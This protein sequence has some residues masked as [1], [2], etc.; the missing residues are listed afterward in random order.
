MRG[1]R[2]RA[3]FLLAAVAGALL[4]GG[5]AL[6]HPLSPSLLRFEAA[7]GGEVT[8]LWRTPAT[9]PTGA[10]TAPALPEGCALHEVSPVERRDEAVEQ[11]MRLDCGDEGLVGR[12]LGVT[13][14]LDGGPPVILHVDLPGGGTYRE[15]LRADRPTV[16][17]PA[18]QGARDVFG[19]YLALG[20]EHLVF[21]AD[22][23]LFVLGLLLLLRGRR[24][25]IAVTSFTVGHSVTLALAA[26]ELVRVSEQ[27][28]EIAI[29]A[30]L[31][32]LADG[33]V[34]RMAAPGGAPEPLIAR[35]PW[36]VPGAFGLL[37]GMGFAGA[38]AEIGLPSE[39]IAW[40]LLAFNLGL[41]VGQLA[42]IGLVLGA[43]AAIPRAARG[44]LTW[45]PW[46]TACLIGA[47]GV[48]WMVERALW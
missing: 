14:L 30:S 25:I 36:V 40:S 28:V 42:V 6:A 39:G 24:L 34:R 13:G 31:L 16:F 12:R 5:P 15:L 20:I 19:A 48:G 35:R 26:L 23:V 46:A 3:A 38:L 37:H 10:T 11:R 44:A 33:A 8:V 7:A 17:V 27:L 1:A 2:R 45:L 43:A 32:V 21:G 47:A 29:A 18:H 4:A 22:H 9:R 41:E